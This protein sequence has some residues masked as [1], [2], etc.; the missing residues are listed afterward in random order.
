MHGSS[1]HVLFLEIS[2]SS[3]KNVHGSSVHV[4]SKVVVVVR[5]CMVALCRFFRKK[6]VAVV[7]MCMVAVC[8]F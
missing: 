5:M 7:R 2:S 8:M 3:R 4:L 6:V 1:V